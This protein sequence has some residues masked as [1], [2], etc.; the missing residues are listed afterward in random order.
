LRRLPAEGR[1]DGLSASDMARARGTP[2]RPM[3]AELAEPFGHLQGGLRGLL[4]A[5]ADVPARARPRLL[6]GQR[7]DDAERGRHA[8][9]ERDVANP[10]RRLARDVL[11]VRGLSPDHDADADDPGVAS[12]R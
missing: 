8:R 6:F 2:P 11:E 7:R 9:G 10:G 1:L 12:G 4:A 3:F 5:V